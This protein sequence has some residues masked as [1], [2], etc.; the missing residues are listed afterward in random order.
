MN[1]ET[2][3]T[4]VNTL[5]RAW[6]NR[7]AQA[8]A[9]LFTEDAS[10]QENPFNEPL[11]GRDAIRAYWADVPRTQDQI[12]AS[13]E[14]LNVAESTGTARWS[15]SYVRIPTG[16]RVHLEGVFVAS[17]DESGQAHAFREWWHMREERPDR[18]VALITGASRGLGATLAGFLAG[19]GYSL[20]LT[21]R[22]GDALQTTAE[23]LKKYHTAVIALAGDVTDPAHRQQLLEAAQSLGRLDLL[24][25]NASELG[26]SPLPALADYPLDVLERVFAANVIAPVAL[27]QILLPLL[28]ASEGLVVNISSDAAVG[29]Y[30]NWG[31]Y[32]ASKAALDLISKTQAGELRSSSVGVVSVDPGDMRT[33]MHQQAF[34]GE[35]ISNRPEPDVTLPFWAWLLAQDHLA[36]SGERFQAQADQWKVPA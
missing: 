23:T 36:V 22:G 6:E 28:K 26:P 18:R 35:D 30:E 33:A 25:N 17:F 34:P 29:G 12:E 1:R 21:A 32:G 3:T 14:V 15:A 11:R 10:Y 13:Y 5:I 27:T 8:A 20:I 9:N 4:W 7:D 2:F 31:G 19:Q 16:E 24:V